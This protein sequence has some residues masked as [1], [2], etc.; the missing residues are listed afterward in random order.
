MPTAMFWEGLERMS[1]SQYHFPV[2]T[3]TVELE[4]YQLL[5]PVYRKFPLLNVPDV[6]LN[7]F[8]VHQPLSCP[9]CVLIF[10]VKGLKL[11]AAVFPFAVIVPGVTSAT[12]ADNCD[13]Q[14]RSFVFATEL[15]GAD[16]G[17]KFDV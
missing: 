4:R 15:I 3:E 6:V 16:G 2:D 17:V 1:H 7:G 11:V 10:T 9:L 8:K 13:L 12:V 14:H 5:G